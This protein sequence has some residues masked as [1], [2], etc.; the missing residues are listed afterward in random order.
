MAEPRIRESGFC[1][2]LFAA[3][4][5]A[6]LSSVG[7]PK[8]QECEM[9]TV[10]ESGRTL[11]TCAPAAAPSSAKKTNGG[12]AGCAPGESKAEAALNEACR[13]RSARSR[14]RHDALNEEL[15]SLDSEE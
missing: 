10:T 12:S 14:R 9:A 6:V 1:A 8:G 4:R 2:R 11:A 15:L 13:L 3:M 5:N 7:G